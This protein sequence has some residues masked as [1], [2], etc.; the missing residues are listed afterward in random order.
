[1]PAARL[2][3]PSLAPFRR[4]AAGCDA[5]TIL[6]MM[7]KATASA[8]KP[9]SYQDTA[10]RMAVSMASVLSGNLLMDTSRWIMCVELAEV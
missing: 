4:A 9:T 10:A 8:L 7:K 3:L 6:Y 2:L 5:H 1:M